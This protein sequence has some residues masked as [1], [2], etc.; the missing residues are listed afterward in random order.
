V[1]SENTGSQNKIISDNGD[2][3]TTYSEYSAEQLTDEF[4]G[5]FSIN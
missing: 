2:G 4:S 3:S 5:I 1:L